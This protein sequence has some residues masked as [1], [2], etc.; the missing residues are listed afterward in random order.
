[1]DPALEWLNSATAW[2]KPPTYLKWNSKASEFEPSIKTHYAAEQ[3][4]RVMVVDSKKHLGH[5][6]NKGL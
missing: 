1:L 5:A 2:D 4:Q 3:S 6:V